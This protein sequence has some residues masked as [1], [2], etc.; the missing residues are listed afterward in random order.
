MI[1]IENVDAEASKAEYEEL[2][3]KLEEQLKVNTELN[4][5]AAWIK[6]CLT[7]GRERAAV[8]ATQVSNKYREMLRKGVVGLPE[9][10]PIDTGGNGEERS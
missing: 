8:L 4:L 2:K 10:N 3:Q 7:N 5:Q 6:E 9:R 1:T